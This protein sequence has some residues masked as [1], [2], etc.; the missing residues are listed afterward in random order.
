MIEVLLKAGAVLED[1][2]WYLLKKETPRRF[3]F[4][5]SS[6][7]PLLPRLQ[8]PKLLPECLEVPMLTGIQ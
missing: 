3:L 1:K 8:P 2:I 7:L 6:A 4:C 5:A